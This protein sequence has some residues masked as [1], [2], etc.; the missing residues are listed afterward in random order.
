MS[1]DRIRELVEQMTVAEQVSL[2]SGEDF[3]SLPAIQRLKWHL[4]RR[5]L[6]P[7][8]LEVVAFHKAHPGGGPK[9]R[10]A[11][12]DT[13]EQEIDL[14]AVVE[15]G[16]GDDAAFQAELQARREI[17]GVL[18]AAWW[19]FIPLLLVIHIILFARTRQ[20]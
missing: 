1:E 11:G 5:R 6:L 3:W 12:R 16:R 2:L 13:C 17:P 4:V 15:R 10:I 7:E 19:L 9:V 14:L 20:T 18:F 8:L